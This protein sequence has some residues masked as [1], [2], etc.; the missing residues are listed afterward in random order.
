MNNSISVM[1]FKSLSKIPTR[2]SYIYR[3]L[4]FARVQVENVKSTLFIW[5]VVNFILAGCL[6][7]LNVPPYLFNAPE[8][9]WS[10]SFCVGITN[11]SFYL[12]N[13]RNLSFSIFLTLVSPKYK[14]IILCLDFRQNLPTIYN[15]Y[16]LL[17]VSDYL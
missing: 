12:K 16:W 17:E 15:L 9:K 6:I 10:I 4:R 7:T 3:I 5:C 14:L 11:R 1:L 8:N 13:V 2:Y